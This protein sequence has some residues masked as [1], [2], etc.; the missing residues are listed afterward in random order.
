MAEDE[1]EVEADGVGETGVWLGLLLGLLLGPLLGL[2]LVLLGLVPDAGAVEELEGAGEL[3]DDDGVG[4]GDVVDGVGVGDFDGVGVA[5][6]DG[7][8][9]GEAETGSTWHWVSV[10]VSALAEVPGLGVAAVSRSPAARAVPGRPTSTLRIRKTPAST[11]SIAT[12]MCL[13]RIRPPLRCSSML[14]SALR[15]FGGD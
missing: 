12:R 11:L 5:D 15:G 1:L 3:E 10:F 2:V 13:R 9:V 8:G 6:F 7:V 14:L 4:V